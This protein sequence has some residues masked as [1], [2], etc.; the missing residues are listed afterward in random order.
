MFA[1]RLR[2]VVVV[3]RITVGAVAVTFAALCAWMGF[4]IQIIALGF[5]ALCWDA[6]AILAIAFCHTLIIRL[7]AIDTRDATFVVGVFDTFAIDVKVPT[8]VELTQG[9]EGA[10]LR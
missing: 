9:I 10:C 5:I 4:V 2:I 3:F 1:G 7:C 6:N 8:V